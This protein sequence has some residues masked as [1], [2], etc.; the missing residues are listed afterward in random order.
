M[1]RGLSVRG[2]HPPCKPRASGDDPHE[3][4][5]EEQDRE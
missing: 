4:T 2:L 3:D 1:I 5:V